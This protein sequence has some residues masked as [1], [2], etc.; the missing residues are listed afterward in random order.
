MAHDHLHPTPYPDVNAVLHLLLANVQS[1]LQENFLGMYLYGS[2]AS[3]DFDPRSSDVD[4]VVITVHDIS[5]EKL[6]A[7]AAMHTHIAASGLKWATKL[8]GSYIPQVAIRR[9][10]P[11]NAQHPSIGVDWAFGVGYH[12]SEWIIQRYILRQ[13]GIVVAGPDPYTLIDP[14]FPDELRHA[15]RT[16][17]HDFWSHQLLDPAWLHS[18]EYQAFAILTMCRALYTLHHGTIVSKPVAA[19]WAKEALDHRWRGM[20]E[21]ALAW[22]YDK[23]VDDMTDMLEFMRYTIEQSHHDEPML[24]EPDDGQHT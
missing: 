12:G 17:L 2:L 13:Q 3:G 6:P 5:V 15:V 10:D 23:H 18:R 16:T 1:L 7:L 8:E 22:R 9:Y 24:D 11:T 4:F 21:R 19:Q 14:I 20:I